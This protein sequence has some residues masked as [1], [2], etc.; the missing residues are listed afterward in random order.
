MG[1]KSAGEYF[2]AKAEEAEAKA[3]NASNDRER[4]TWRG[5]AKEYRRLANQASAPV[6]PKPKSS[7]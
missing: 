4:G 7:S 2:F 6:P 1:E 5:I 3:A